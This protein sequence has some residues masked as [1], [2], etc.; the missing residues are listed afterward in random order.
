[1][2]LLSLIKANMLIFCLIL[3]GTLGVVAVGVA[4]GIYYGVFYNK[5][6]ITTKTSTTT[7]T[8]STTT[9]TIYQNLCII[10][11]LFFTL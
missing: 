5:N 10:I 6:A 2:N 1:M 11:L 3:A 8:T 9:I 4:C 7:S